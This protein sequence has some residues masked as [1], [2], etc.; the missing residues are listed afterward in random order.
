M[1]IC[2]YS[3]GACVGIGDSHLYLTTPVHSISFAAMPRVARVVVA[4]VPHH[5]TQRGNN[6]QDVFFTHDDRRLY[7]QCL[8]EQSD[9]YGLTVHGY[10]LMTNHVHLVAT[11]AGPGSLAKAVGRTDYLYTQAINRRHGRSGHLWQNRFFSAP[12]DE[13]HYWT[14]LAYVEQNPVRAGMIRRAWDYGW[15]SAAVH[16][17]GPDGHGLVDLVTWKSWSK[18]IDWKGVLSQRQDDA[19]VRA[20]RRSTRTGRPLGSDRFIAK[21]ETALGRRLRPLPVGRPRKPKPASPSGRAKVPARR[22]G[23]R[24]NR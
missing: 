5:V 14:A 22:S 18:G 21:L 8:R 19:T 10:C 4:G 1:T 7:L 6:R 3:R 15:S 9:R 16:V 11:P 17:G 13:T 20:V 12:L 24:K 23:K 2:E